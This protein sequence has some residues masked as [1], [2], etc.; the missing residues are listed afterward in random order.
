M[1]KPFKLTQEQAVRVMLLKKQKVTG[2][3]AYA[4]TKEVAGVGTLNLHKIIFKLR[5]KGMK[6]KEEWMR[7]EKTKTN[8]KQFY[9]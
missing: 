6:I 7:N 3:T 2:S 8:Y 1:K 5:E 9:L 4:Y